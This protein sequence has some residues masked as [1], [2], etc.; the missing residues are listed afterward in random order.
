MKKLMFAVLV[1]VGLVSVA[2][3]EKPAAAANAVA[4]AVAEDVIG[5]A[6]ELLEGLHK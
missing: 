5:G 4:P 3:T 1:T 2:E 6:L